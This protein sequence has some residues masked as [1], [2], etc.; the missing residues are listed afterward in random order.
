MNE[1]SGISFSGGFVP[2]IRCSKS[3]IYTAFI[4]YFFYLSSII[5]IP[6]K[7]IS[8][9]IPTKITQICVVQNPTCDVEKKQIKTVSMPV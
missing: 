9:I 6:F 7:M 4:I 5:I 3:L 8:L 1:M 2:L